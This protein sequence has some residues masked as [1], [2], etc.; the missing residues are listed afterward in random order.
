MEPNITQVAIF[1]KV[2][3]KDIHQGQSSLEQ[4]FNGFAAEAGGQVQ[5]V[6]N[7]W[8]EFK[9]NSPVS[10]LDGSR[11]LRWILHFLQEKCI[12]ITWV[13]PKD[14]FFLWSE[15]GLWMI[16]WKWYCFE[17]HK[18]LPATL[19]RVCRK[20]LCTTRLI[21]RMVSTNHRAYTRLAG[22]RSRIIAQNS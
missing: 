3:N 6:L 7:L 18:C 12:I 11:D 10:M 8:R 5:W 1:L 20:W 14:L 22:G 9:V 13:F 4:I 19:E 16:C 15:P 21:E 17:G 2:E